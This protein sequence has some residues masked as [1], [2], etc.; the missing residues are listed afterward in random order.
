[1]YS[2][3][4]VHQLLQELYIEKEFKCDQC[5][6][7][8]SYKQSLAKHQRDKHNIII[9]TS[10]NIDNSNS[11][12]TSNSHN[13]TNCHNTTN[14]TNTTT[15]NSHNITENS[16]NTTNIPITINVYGKENIDHVINDQDFLLQCLKS[17][18]TNGIPDL[19]KQIWLNDDHKENQNLMFKRQHTPKTFQVY[20]EVDGIHQW[21]IEDGDSILEELILKGRELII[22]YNSHHLTLS[23]TPTNDEKDMYDLRSNR[24]SDVKHKKRGVY[25]PICNRLMVNF[26]NHKLKKLQTNL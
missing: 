1:L 26:L 11:N 15:N 19:I 5:E 8:F 18:H 10:N 25:K 9:V 14:T 12:N 13:N 24:L 22:K 7:T 17:V 16:H 2:S 20:R 6:K 4:E 21:I 23:P 3:I